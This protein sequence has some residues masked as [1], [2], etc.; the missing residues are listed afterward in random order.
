MPRSILD[1]AN[2]HQ[3]TTSPTAEDG[4][5]AGYT[6]G[7]EWINMSER[8][9]FKCVDNTDGQAVWQLLGACISVNGQDGVVVLDGESV[10]IVI[11][12]N[13][14]STADDEALSA[15]QGNIINISILFINC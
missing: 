11:V 6:V 5:T 10:G 14:N 15:K 3:A 1:D 13:L 4:L 12:D 7:S 8:L 2:V 9:L